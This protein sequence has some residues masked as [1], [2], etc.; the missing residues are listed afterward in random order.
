MTKIEITAPSFEETISG[1]VVIIG[2]T[3]TI[4]INS[5]LITTTKQTK[6]PAGL[7]L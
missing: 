5:S 2:Q 6:H 1:L 7:R 4:P 3:W